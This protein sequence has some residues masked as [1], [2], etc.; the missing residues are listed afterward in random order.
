MQSAPQGPLLPSSEG[1][2]VFADKS[3]VAV[4]QL[5]EA[6]KSGNVALIG[7]LLDE[8]HQ[9]CSGN[10]VSNA[11][12]HSLLRIW[13]ACQGVLEGNLDPKVSTQRV[14]R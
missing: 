3:G 7:G 14:D 1:I 8:L 2:D 12:V 10:T 6:L 4:G 5:M 9:M 11:P 13:A